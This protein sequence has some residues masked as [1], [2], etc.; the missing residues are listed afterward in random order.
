MHFLFFKSEWTFKDYPLEIWS[1]PN[2][3]QDDIKFGAKFINWSLFVAHGSTTI[4]AIINV[5]VKQKFSDLFKSFKDT[6]NYAIFK[7][8]IDT[9]IKQELKPLFVLNSIALN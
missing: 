1:N 6:Q 2:A 8:C 7:S 3:E 4:E 5:K 9:A